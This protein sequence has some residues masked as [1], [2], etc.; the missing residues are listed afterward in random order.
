VGVGVM[1]SLLLGLWR[2]NRG[3]GGYS[4][5]PR[6]GNPGVLSPFFFFFG[7][8]YQ[9]AHGSRSGTSHGCCADCFLL[10]P[11]AFVLVLP[12]V[13]GV[14]GGG[15]VWALSDGVWGPCWGSLEGCIRRVCYVGSHR[16]LDLDAQLISV[17]N[18]PI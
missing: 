8:N 13:S 14:K 9:F 3:D 10:A 6:W 17:T 2:R 7:R 12:L 11:L 4:L 16:L 5:H 15:V 1:G 18:Y